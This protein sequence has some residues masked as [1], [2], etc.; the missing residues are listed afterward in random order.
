MKEI[1]AREKLITL[2][3]SQAHQI[4]DLKNE[5]E[6][7]IRKPVSKQFN[8]YTGNYKDPV[9]I[10]TAEPLRPNND[11]VETESIAFAESI[12]TQE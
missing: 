9:V 5:I 7:L 2:I 3:Q 11:G 12:A 10:Q 8:R 6:K 1:E 4:Q